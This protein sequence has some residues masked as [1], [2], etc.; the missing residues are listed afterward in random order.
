MKEEQPILKLKEFTE[1]LLKKGMGYTLS[2]KNNID[3]NNYQE[4]A[5]WYLKHDYNKLGVVLTMII[6]SDFELESKLLEIVDTAIGIL[7]KGDFK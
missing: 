7:D 4:I 5:F 2:L 6:R 3:N 1:K